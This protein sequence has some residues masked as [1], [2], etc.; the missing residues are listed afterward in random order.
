MNYINM[1]R[2]HIDLIIFLGYLKVNYWCL[3]II[4]NMQ[5]D[6]DYCADNKIYSI[7]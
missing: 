3:D 2:R 4:E 1:G 5:L 6:P 7:L